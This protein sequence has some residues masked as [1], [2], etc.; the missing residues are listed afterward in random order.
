VRSRYFLVMVSV[1][2]KGQMS[3]DVPGQCPVSDPNDSIGLVGRRFCNPVDEST[4][5]SIVLM[6]GPVNQKLNHAA[7]WSYFSRS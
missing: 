4:G 7:R 6:I 2:G 3:V 5:V 1:S